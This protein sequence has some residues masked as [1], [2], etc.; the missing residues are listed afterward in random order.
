M[1][2][3]LV[4]DPSKLRVDPEDSLL[5]KDPPLEL[6]PMHSQSSADVILQHHRPLNWLLFRRA[7]SAEEVGL[8]LF[9]L[10]KVG[11]PPRVGLL[12]PP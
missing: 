1:L 2:R 8:H 10:T 7:L 6:A 12:S 5:T 4:G 3:P 11:P 9:N